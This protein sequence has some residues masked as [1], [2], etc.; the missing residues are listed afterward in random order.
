[1]KA[2]FA[3][4]TLIGATGAP[5]KETAEL[6]TDRLG[7]AGASQ[8]RPEKPQVLIDK[9]NP[10]TVDY[11]FFLN[12]AIVHRQSFVYAIVPLMSFIILTT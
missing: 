4:L 8:A 6:V 1:M 3:K 11:H 12:G 5:G 2:S 10:L 7:D 9:R